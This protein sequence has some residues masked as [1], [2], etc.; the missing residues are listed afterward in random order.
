MVIVSWPLAKHVH[1][2]LCAGQ[3]LAGV[4]CEEIEYSIAVSL[5]S[6]PCPLCALLWY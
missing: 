4:A 2:V 1:I 3:D 5:G 6:A